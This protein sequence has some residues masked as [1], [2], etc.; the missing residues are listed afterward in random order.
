MTRKLEPLVWGGAWCLVRAVPRGEEVGRW[1][2]LLCEW[3]PRACLSVWSSLA[4]GQVWWTA[5]E[6]RAWG[7]VLTSLPVRC[8]VGVLPSARHAVSGAHG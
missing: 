1:L 6:A 8:P 3:A 4:P 2:P 7:A 5:A